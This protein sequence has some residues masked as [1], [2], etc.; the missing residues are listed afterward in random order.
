MS[1]LSELLGNCSVSAREGSY[2]SVF[3]PG[4]QP[5]AQLVD[6]GLSSADDSPADLIAALAHSR[7][8]SYFLKAYHAALHRNQLPQDSTE[9]P[10]DLLQRLLS[11]FTVR[12]PHIDLDPK[13]PAHDA[14]S[15]QYWNIGL[16]ARTPLDTDCQTQIEFLE[17]TK[18]L[19]DR[20]VQIREIWAI[21]AILLQERGTTTTVE[22]K[23]FG[24]FDH[25]DSDRPLTLA[26]LWRDHKDLPHRAPVEQPTDVADEDNRGL[27]GQ[28]I[29]ERLL[30]T[31]TPF[32]ATTVVANIA[33]PA[34]SPSEQRETA[35]SPLSSPQSE[36]AQNIFFV[37]PAAL[38]PILRTVEGLV[39]GSYVLEERVMRLLLELQS[40]LLR[41]SDAMESCG[42]QECVKSVSD[43]DCSEEDEDERLRGEMLSAVQALTK[44]T[45]FA[46]YRP[47][48]LGDTSNVVQGSISRELTG[49]GVADVLRSEHLNKLLE[50]AEAFDKEDDVSTVASESELRELQGDLVHTGDPASALPVYSVLPD[51]EGA[52]ASFV[53]TAPQLFSETFSFDDLAADLDREKLYLQQ[54]W[55][56]RPLTALKTEDISSGD[57]GGGHQHTS[58]HTNHD[59]PQ[60]DLRFALHL[61]LDYLPAIETDVTAHFGGEGGGEQLQHLINRRTRALL[62]ELKSM[63][64]RLMEQEV[65]NNMAAPPGNPFD[66]GELLTLPQLLCLTDLRPEI[67]RTDAELI[68]SAATWS[69]P[70]FGERRGA[71]LRCDSFL[72]KKNADL[73]Q[74]HILQTVME[75][76]KNNLVAT[77]MSELEEYNAARGRRVV[78]WSQ[79]TVGQVQ[80]RA[81][82]VLEESIEKRSG[83][84]TVERVA[85]LAALAMRLLGVCHAQPAYGTINDFLWG[86]SVPCLQLPYQSDPNG[87]CSNSMSLHAFI[88]DR[89]HPL[90]KVL[91]PADHSANQKPLLGVFGED[92]ERDL[93]RLTDL[94]FY[95]P[96]GA[97]DSRSETVQR[98]SEFFENL[99]KVLE[100]AETQL[101]EY[102][103][104]LRAIPD[105]GSEVTSVASSADL[106][107]ML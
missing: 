60:E 46:V 83:R 41:I 44:A 48:P 90:L 61:S 66:V 50:Q 85:S 23:L 40:V 55:V 12:I 67:L 13:L 24:G 103:A 38:L 63:K 36:H 65:E 25:R 89:Y 77:G 14:K 45:A 93:R 70:P 82:Q 26:D 91:A 84:G 79:P 87:G 97:L 10:C 107:A 54:K 42:V 37:F 17:R 86:T 49:P 7:P 104:W 30:R 29:M 34:S 64:I 6:L 51:F 2:P 106:D 9:S 8:P 68:R 72:Q 71:P 74:I 11:L 75:A 105:Q 99:T 96:R 15:F 102:A 16:D 27:V 76:L 57:G 3:I 56:P 31:L 98:R 78:G 4:T 1:A 28:S 92:A 69:L 62:G 43:K 32:L 21:F 19:T 5:L 22:G 101:N 88:R 100:K 53:R 94:Y 18:Q 20:F 58:Q 33:A 47:V 73:I 80:E 59:D 35:D 52:L 39:G 95:D 81:Q